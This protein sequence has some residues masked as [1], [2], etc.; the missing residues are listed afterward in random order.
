MHRIKFF[1]LGGWIISHGYYL[2]TFHSEFQIVQLIFEGSLWWT[3]SRQFAWCY[4]EGK[5][6]V[7]S[8]V[9]SSLSEKSRRGLAMFVYAV[10]IEG[11][12]SCMAGL[13]SKYCEFFVTMWRWGT[14]LTY[15]QRLLPQYISKQRIHCYLVRDHEAESARATCVIVWTITP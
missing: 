7:T 6:G 13:L 8:L 9:P 12:H 14:S 2:M 4:E 1:Q 15:Q 10:K 11:A 3:W 5:R